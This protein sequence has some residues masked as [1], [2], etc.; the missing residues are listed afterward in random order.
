MA[1]ACRY[2]GVLLKGLAVRPLSRPLQLEVTGIRTALLCEPVAGWDSHHRNDA[3]CSASRK[4][5]RL[6]SHTNILVRSL[7]PVYITDRSDADLL[8]FIS[9]KSCISVPQYFP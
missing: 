6:T 8:H 9:T 1:E 7:V 4:L 2:R 3:W 5:K